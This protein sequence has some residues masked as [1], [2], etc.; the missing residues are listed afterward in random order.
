M[1]LFID[2]PTSC[3]LCQT[4]IVVGIMKKLTINNRDVFVCDSCCFDLEQSDEVTVNA[5]KEE[6]PHD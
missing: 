4:T 1:K 5:R 3:E 2:R 6:A